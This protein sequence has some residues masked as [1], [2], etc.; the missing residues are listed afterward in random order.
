[1][2]KRTSAPACFPR[3]RK[4][5][6]IRFSRGILLAGLLL[7][8]ASASAFTLSPEGTALERRLSRVGESRLQRI[9]ESWAL[10][11]IHHF[12]SRKA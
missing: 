10:R 1:M 7:L 4:P 3:S 5:R 12:T 2:S 9:L 11:G 6:S 8:P